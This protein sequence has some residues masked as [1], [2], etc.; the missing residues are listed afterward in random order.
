MAVLKIISVRAASVSDAFVYHSY[1]S[2]H[3]Q[4]V[5]IN[6]FAELIRKPINLPFCF[7]FRVIVSRSFVCLFLDIISMEFFLC[8]DLMTYIL[9]ART[10]LRFLSHSG[11]EIPIFDILLSFLFVRRVVGVNI[12]PVTSLSLTT[13]SNNFSTI[14]I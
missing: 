3:L 5:R 4:N 2:Q 9:C 8:Y 14:I 1:H 12:F 10:Q 6:S 7:I 13:S 11:L